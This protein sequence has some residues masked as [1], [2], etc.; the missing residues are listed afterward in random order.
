MATRTRGGAALKALFIGNSFT[1]RNDL[2]GLVAKLAE[3][4]G[5]GLEHRLISAGGEIR[6]GEGRMALVLVVQD[7]LV[8]IAEEPLP[9]QADRDDRRAQLPADAGVGVGDGLLRLRSV[10]PRP[11]HVE[12]RLR[13]RG[14]DG[15]VEEPD[16]LVHAF[17]VLDRQRALFLEDYMV[18][19]T[20][21]N[22]LQR[23]AGVPMGAKRRA[24]GAD[25]PVLKGLAPRGREPCDQAGEIVA[26]GEAVAN[27]ERLQ[28]GTASNAGGHVVLP[29]HA[30]KGRLAFP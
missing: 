2:P 4:R 12:D 17:C 19:L 24:S 13:A 21:L 27:E 29:F 11:G 26:G 9:G 22:R 1:A 28:R 30:P 10:A 23:L 3:A 6:P 25:Q 20:A 18:V 5:R 15:P 16:V 14:P 7:G 8:V